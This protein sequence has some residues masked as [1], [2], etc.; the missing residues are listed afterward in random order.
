MPSSKP[1]R[2]SKPVAADID[3]FGLTDTGRVRSDNQDHFLIASLHKLLKVQR[4]SLPEPNLTDLVSETRGYLFLVADGV[5]GQPDGHVASGTVLRTVAEYVTDFMNLYRRLDS[6]METPF[7]DEL[8]RSVERSHAVL[9]KQA[10]SDGSDESL[11]TTLTMVAVLWPRA[12][13]VQVGDSRCYRLR[14]GALELLSQDQTIAQAL[15]DSG[16]LTP[17]E[18]RRSPFRGILASAI[19]GPTADPMTFATDCRWDDIL[20]LCTDGLTR[21]VSDEE[22]EAELRTIESAEQSCRRLVERALERGGRDNVT[23]VIGRLRP[24]PGSDAIGVDVDAA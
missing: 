16:A 9:R 17:E 19:G 18:A 6:Q 14:D 4:T 13:L 2:R 3:V 23:V 11:A 5:S 8:A 20:L 22:I 7:L 24:Q 10:P 15:V 1:A 21:H 12:Y